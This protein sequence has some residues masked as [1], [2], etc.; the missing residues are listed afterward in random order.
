MEYNLVW[1]LSGEPPMFLATDKKWVY[2]G[3]AKLMVFSDVLDAMKTAD[4][5]GNGA[6]V[7]LALSDSK[8][9]YP[10]TC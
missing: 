2:R 10:F 9:P 3:E 7:C 1:R 6:R 4:I 8:E 5:I